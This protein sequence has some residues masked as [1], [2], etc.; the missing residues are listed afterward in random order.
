MKKT[1]GFKQTF[2]SRLKNNFSLRVHMTLILFATAMAGAVASKLFLMIGIANPAI[3]YPLTVLFAYFIF[4]IAVKFWLRI[5]IGT[6][7]I[8]SSS[9]I[10]P[11]MPGDIQMPVNISGSSD[12]FSGGGGTFSGGGA[13][14]SFDSPASG[15][16]DISSAADAA[17]SIDLDV[18]EGIGVIIVLLLLAALLAAVLGAGVYLVYNA[19]AILSEVAFDSF[20]ALSLTRKTREMKDGSWIGSVLKG[21]WKQFLII[22]AISAIA[23][24]AIHYF[25]PG[26]IK[27]SQLLKVIM[28]SGILN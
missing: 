5:I 2:I 23:G 18:D 13:S 6:P 28:D 21:T 24:L 1:F 9:S 11:E 4:F 10:D 15:G 8:H 27:L 14:A 12:S 20:L 22:L 17:S 3:R 16:S 7:L 19:P 26:V 25:F